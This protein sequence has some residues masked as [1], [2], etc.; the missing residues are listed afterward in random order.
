MKSIKKDG[1]PRLAVVSPLELRESD[2][3]V[4]QKQENVFPRIKT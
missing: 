3:A 4:D 2:D 1:T